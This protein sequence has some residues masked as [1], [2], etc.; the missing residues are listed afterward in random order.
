MTFNRIW[1]TKNPNQGCEKRVL[2]LCSAGLLRSP[3]VAW[4]LGNAP[5]NYNTRAAGT[6]WEFA[7]VGVDSVLLEWAEEIVCV[8]AE[9]RDR[10]LA[11]CA[12]Q[13]YEIGSKPIVVLDIPDVY[14]RRAPA[15]VQLIE[16]QYKAYLD[17]PD[18]S[19]ST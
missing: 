3:T 10:L 16:E 8:S 12:E 4:V 13:R 5:Y 1:N 19:V 14:R 9:I 17:G 18:V 11:Y 15:L 7:L 2:C 6:S